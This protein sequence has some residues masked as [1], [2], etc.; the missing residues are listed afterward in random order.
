[1]INRT[2]KALRIWR[3]T[4]NQQTCSMHQYVNLELLPVPAHRM[5]FRQNFHRQ[6]ALSLIHQ[7]HRLR[8]K[9][10]TIL[11]SI[12]TIL[13]R[14]SED[15]AVLVWRNVRYYICH[16]FFFMNSVQLIITINFGVPVSVELPEG[17]GCSPQA[18]RRISR[19]SL[20]KPAE[21]VSLAAQAAK[22]GG[23]T[24]SLRHE[25]SK[26]IDKTDEVKK[27]PIINPLVRLPTWP[28]KYFY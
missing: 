6:S 18:T 15:S 13:A 1:M 7:A 14:I 21:I 24:M 17:T 11:I 19:G 25:R 28:S 16:I 26:S 27:L 3:T 9:A 2:S 20:L 23:S 12:S 4:I 5:I 22:Y 8:S 10:S